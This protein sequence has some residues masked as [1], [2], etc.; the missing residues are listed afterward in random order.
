M[1]EEYGAPE[2]QYMIAGDCH[3]KGYATELA[4]VVVQDAFAHN[5]TNRIVAT[6]DIPNTGSIRVLEKLGF[7]QV[8]Q[9]Y[10]YGSG[11]MYLYRL[12]RN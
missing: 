3:G 4:S 9:V 5:K 10:A 11:D 12:V 2:L 7:E 1:S 6:V 8:G